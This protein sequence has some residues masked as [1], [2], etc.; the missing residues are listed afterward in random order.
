MRLRSL[1]LRHFRNV[2]FASLAFSGRQ[3]FLVGG[4][5]QAE[6]LDVQKRV[7]DLWAHHARVATGALKV[8]DDLADRAQAFVSAWQQP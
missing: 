3:Q 5:G 6:V 4:N 8:G 1:S 7:G 2:G